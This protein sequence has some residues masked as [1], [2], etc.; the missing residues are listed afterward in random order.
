MVNPVFLHRSAN[1]TINIFMRGDDTGYSNVISGVTGSDGLNTYNTFF[2]FPVGTD[3]KLRWYWEGAFAAGVTINL[4][5][6]L[7]DYTVVSHNKI[8][9]I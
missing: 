5:C 8:I 4:M 1:K 6:Y 9:K 3:R 2:A 7:L